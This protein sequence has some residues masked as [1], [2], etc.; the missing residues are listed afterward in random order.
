MN[1]ILTESIE[2]LRS[3]ELLQIVSLCL[4]KDCIVYVYAKSNR[5]RTN[6]NPNEVQTMLDT[7]S[8][9]GTFTQRKNVGH[10]LSCSQ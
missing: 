10:A 8:N 2:K 3:R 4:L 1:N 9:L 7:D 5:I 6:F